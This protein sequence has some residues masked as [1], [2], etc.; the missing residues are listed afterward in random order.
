MNPAP[1]NLG[2]I[3]ATKWKKLKETSNDNVSTTISELEKA[4]RELEIKW[5]SST[6]RDKY[7]E[8]ER[9]FRPVYSEDI[10]LNDRVPSL[11]VICASKIRCYGHE[12]RID[13]LPHELQ[14]LVRYLPG[15][16][17][18]ST[19]TTNVIRNIDS[20]EPDQGQGYEQQCVLPKWMMKQTKLTS[21]STGNSQDVPH[22]EGGTVV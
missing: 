11:R 12:I 15:L 18:S 6:Q 13:E 21:G 22:I 7:L 17:A 10:W 4:G 16:T 3:A 2:E 1:L 19:A 5:Q 8:A 20:N 9:S 14:T